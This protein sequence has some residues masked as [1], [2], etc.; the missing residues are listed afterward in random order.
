M[1]LARRL[2]GLFAECFDDSGTCMDNRHIFVLFP[3]IFAAF[4][5]PVDIFF[6]QVQCLIVFMV[7]VEL[8]VHCTAEKSESEHSASLCKARR[9]AGDDRL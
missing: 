4:Q 5:H 7:I 3:R 6:V 8:P 9:C 1:L 2:E